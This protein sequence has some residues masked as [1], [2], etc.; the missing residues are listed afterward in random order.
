MQCIKINLL[1]VVCMLF[2]VFLSSPLSAL[3]IDGYENLLTAEIDLVKFENLLLEKINNE[4]SL[5]GL[6]PLGLDPLAKSVAIDHSMFLLDKGYLSYYDLNFKGPD[7]RFS[8]YGGSGVLTEIIKGFQ[9][10]SA[11]QY[12]ELLVNQLI[13][14]LV[15]SE[16]DSKI[17]FNPF[18]KSFGVGVSRSENKTKFIITLEFVVSGAIVS[19]LKLPLRLDEEILVSGKINS[20]YKFKAVSIAYF[21]ENEAKKSKFEYNEINIDDLKP[22]FP[23]QDFIAYT[24]VSKRRWLNF[25]K[26]IG[27]VGT[28]GASPFT[29]GASTI[30]T[31][32]LVNS[33]RD[34]NPKEIPLKGGINVNSDGSFS[35]KI[36]LNYKNMPGLYFISVIGEINGVNYPVVLGRRAVRVGLN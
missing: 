21:D 2:V 34:S 16:D 17:I 26:G 13:D 19:P 1:N 27:V 18:V 28:I 36:R 5:R 11:I 32:L 35:G 4:R 10:E 9:S 23:P 14:A 31:P 25:F 24:D 22:Y 30:L 29:G 6:S 15:I 12:S 8:N 7:E 3:A 20:P 33:M